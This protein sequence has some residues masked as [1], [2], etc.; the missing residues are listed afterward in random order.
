MMRGVDKGGDRLSRLRRGIC[1]ILASAFGFALMAFF[2]RLCDDFGGS[3]SSFQKSLFRNA[4]AFTIATGVFLRSRGA[5]IRSGSPPVARLPGRA[6]LLLLGRSIAGTV[7]IFGN[8]YALSIIPI[9]E[10]MTLN[11]TAPFFTVLF[12]WLFLR[13]KAGLRAI[14]CLLVAFAGALLVMKPGFQGAAT[15][16]T[17]CALAGGLG[18]GVAYTCVREL[19]LLKVEGSFVV[20]FFSGFS[21]LASI[22][23]V[24]LDPAPMTAAQTLILLG[25]GCG[26]AIGQFGVTAAYRFAA[27]REIALFDYSN[28]IFTSLFGFVFFSQVPDAWSVCGFL[29]IVVASLLSRGG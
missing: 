5:A 21:T 13:E 8:F 12:S 11:K 9:G 24:L 7:G 10:A 15:F 23:F 1:C 2:V 6:W 17:V 16:A 26:A 28:V 27:P 29:L 18:A 20:L 25:A 3:V 14:G 4:I 19:G 22:P